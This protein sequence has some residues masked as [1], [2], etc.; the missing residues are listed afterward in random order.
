[1]FE[2]AGLEEAIEAL[3]E[4]LAERGHSCG[5]LVIGG[6]SLLM[7]GLVRRP[8]ADLDVVG[9]PSRDGYTKADSLPDFLQDAAREVGDAF[10]LGDRWLN[11]GPAGLIDFGLP[12][13]LEERVT[14]RRYGGLEVHLPAREDL[15][16]FKLYACVD[17]G[18]RSKHFA[19]L[20]NLPASR[21]ELLNAARWTR[22][23]DPSQGFKQELTRIL[24]LL[25]CEVS[26]GD[27]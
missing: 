25:G 26:D 1:M 10:G 27:L 19:D 8:T 2:R 17:Q 15:I 11:T 3:G 16:C 20:E 21:S 23:Q 9:L 18:E 22:S 7:L 14:I 13:G 24:P 12:P 4:T 6:G 5:I